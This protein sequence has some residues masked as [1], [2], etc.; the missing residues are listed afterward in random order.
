[1]IAFVEV[2]EAGLE[3]FLRQIEPNGRPTGAALFCFVSF[4]YGYILNLHVPQKFHFFKQDS[5]VRRHNH[6]QN[7][8]GS[9][10]LPIFSQIS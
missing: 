3:E 9:V 1:M 2:A 10:F 6:L 5:Q 7:N 8:G 4:L